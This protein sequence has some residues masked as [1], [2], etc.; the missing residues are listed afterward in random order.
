AAM[1]R[2]DWPQRFSHVAELSAW[3]RS[4]LTEMGFV[5]VAN[6]VRTSP[7]V[8]TI[9]L[10]PELDSGKIGALMQ[11]NGFLLSCNSEYLRRRNWIQV[12]LMGECT[13]EKV[14]S[15]ANALNRV[16]FRR[17]GSTRPRPASESVAR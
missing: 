15:V 14:T 8:V 4:K 6:D 9:A 10:A 16:C 7:A 3:L 11:E 17:E 1:K 5:L 13:A 2:V 12:C